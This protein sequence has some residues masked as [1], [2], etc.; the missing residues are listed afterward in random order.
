MESPSGSIDQRIVIG[1]ERP[2]DNG[3][4][5]S[6]LPTRNPSVMNDDTPISCFSIILRSQR[7]VQHWFYPLHQNIRSRS[8]KH[9]RLWLKAF[10]VKRAEHHPCSPIVTK[11]PTP[12][13]KCAPHSCSCFICVDISVSHIQLGAAIRVDERVGH[14]VTDRAGGD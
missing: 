10:K 12:D 9:D 3:S 7:P 2:P 6:L 8:P 5:A 4:D 1:A 14:G 11:E 13:L